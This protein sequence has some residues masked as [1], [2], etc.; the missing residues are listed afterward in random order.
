MTIWL[1][2]L[3]YLLWVCFLGVLITFLQDV[4]HIVGVLVHEE[5]VVAKTL[6]CTNGCCDTLGYFLLMKFWGGLNSVIQS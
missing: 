2:I 6:F 4:F 3:N 1:L 5:Y